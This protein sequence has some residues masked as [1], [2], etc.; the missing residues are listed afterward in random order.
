MRAA[1]LVVI[2]CL[3]VTGSV[4][5]EAQPHPL[6]LSEAMLLALKH[7]PALAAAGLTVETAEADLARARSRFLPTVNFNETYN[8]SDNPTQVFMGK[9]NQRVFTGQDFLLN[10]LNNPN[11]YG[12][13]RTGLVMRQPLFQAGEAHLGYQQARL[14]REMAAAY[15]L[16]AR[17]QLLFQVTQ[18]YFGVQLAQENL[19]VVQQARHTAA[20]R[21][22]QRKRAYALVF[23]IRARA[24]L[25]IRNTDALHRCCCAHGNCCACRR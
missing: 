17:Q 21:T 5:A 2:F 14:G 20:A 24:P 4:M 12:N 25:P 6:T 1:I 11:A 16:S 22:R 19:A 3:G 10:N 7:N 13:F 9:L 18:A 8:F 23:I 15:V